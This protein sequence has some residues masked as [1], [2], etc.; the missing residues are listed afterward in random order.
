MGEQKSDDY[1]VSA[2]ALSAHTFTDADNDGASTYYDCND[3]DPTIYTWAEEIAVD[4][5][6][7]LFGHRPT[8]YFHRRRLLIERLGLHLSHTNSRSFRR[9]SHIF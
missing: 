4:G 3:N 7:K 1:G 8:A 6:S 5:I 2:Y 9:N